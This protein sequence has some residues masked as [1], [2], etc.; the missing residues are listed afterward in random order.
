M[1]FARARR[2]P[3]HVS[4]RMNK[5][6]AEYAGVLQAR[7]LAGEVAHWRHEPLTFR[8]TQDDG[9]QVRYT[10]DF[11]VIE[12]D[13]TITL[14]DVKPAWFSKGDGQVKLRPEDDAIIKIRMAADQFPEFR[15]VMVGKAPK[16]HGGEWMEQEV[17][18]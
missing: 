9:E 3:R 11:R 12:N 13:G 16:K 1:T 10:P 7:L 14:V 8:L 15:W 5:A 17:S 4:G 2:R 18:R 6:E